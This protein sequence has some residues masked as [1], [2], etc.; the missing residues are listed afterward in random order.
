MNF[1]IEYQQCTGKFAADLELCCREPPPGYPVPI[2]VSI[3]GHPP[4]SSHIQLLPQQS[5][6]Q[7]LSGTHSGTS[8]TPTLPGGNPEEQL[9][10]TLGKRVSRVRIPSASQS[11]IVVGVPPTDIDSRSLSI[12]GRSFF[13]KDL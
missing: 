5:Q 9:S 2:P 13:C 8:G 7:Q 11:G 1:S 3:R 4:P 10:T 12:P 6:L